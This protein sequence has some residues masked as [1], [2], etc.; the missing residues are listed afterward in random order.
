[1]FIY[2]NG[3]MTDREPYTKLEQ[4]VVVLRAVWDMIDGMVNY[5]IFEKEHATDN[6][7]LFFKSNSTGQLF[8]ILLADFLSKPKKG[9]FNLPVPTGAAKTD[10]TFLFYLQ[11]IGEMP[12]LNPNPQDIL[13]PVQQFAS[14]LEEECV[15]ENV[16][17]Q[18]I[19]TETNICVKRITFLKICGDIAKHNFARLDT[20]V[21]RIKKVFEENSVQIDTG[22]GF[23]ILPEFYEWFHTD[24]F[25]YHASTIA[26][27]LN[28]IRWG[29]FEYLKPEFSRSFEKTDP[30]P[31]GYRFNHPAECCDPLTRA[32][33]WD[34]MNQVRSRPHFPH[35]QTTKMLKKRY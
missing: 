24:I 12:E 35:F 15:V 34:L 32:M 28:N 29:I 26:E 20:N 1:M 27:Y 25:H 9:T 18:S 16:W 2:Y 30:Q 10:H 17:F 33:Y 13:G 5:E 6:A 7:Q 11:R 23:L 14:W 19:E 21:K 22:Q 8:N 31:V 4:E 3:S